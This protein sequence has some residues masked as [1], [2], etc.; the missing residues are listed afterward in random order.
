M[1]TTVVESEFRS[2]L[3]Q[4]MERFG[5]VVAMA[6][7]VGVSD[8]AVYKWLSGRGQPSV[9]NLVAVARAAKVSLEWLATGVDA[10]HSTSGPGRANARGKDFIFMPRN[11]ARFPN[12]REGVIRSDQVVDWL[13]FRAEWVKR[14]LNTDARDLILI[15]VIGDSM[16]PTLEDADLIVANL[17]EPR[18]RQDGIYLTRTDGG[19]TVKRVQRRPDGKLLVRSDNPAYEPMVVAAERVKILGR[20]IWAGGRI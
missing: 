12:S 20:V 16:A 5:S 14:R 19:L 15:E 1:S 2:R 7:A 18:F 4:V 13:A 3:A 9:T 11:H 8:N 10:A 6:N 17:S